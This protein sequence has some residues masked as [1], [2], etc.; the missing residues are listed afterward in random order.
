MGRQSCS[1]QMTLRT[2]ASRKTDQV[3]LL[4]RFYALCGYAQ[5]DIVRE[6]DDGFDESESRRTE[7]RF[8]Q[9]GLIDFQ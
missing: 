4:H 3:Q 5:P 7:L 9:K 1:E 2:I 8:L 6:N